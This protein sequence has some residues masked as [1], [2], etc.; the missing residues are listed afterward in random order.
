MANSITRDDDTIRIEPADK[1]RGVG[2]VGGREIRIDHLRPLRDVN[3]QWIAQTPFGWQRDLHK[4]PLRLST[5]G[6]ILWGE[7]DQGLRITTGFARELGIKVMLKPH[8]WTHAGWCGEI[9][10]TSEEDWAAWFDDYRNFILHYARFAEEH[11][12]DA[13]V[14]GTE[15]EGTTQRTEDWR[16]IIAAVR[17]VYTGPI[18]FGANWS[19]EFEHIEFWDELD[20]IG[21]HAY[22]PLSNGKKPTID[23]LRAN[24]QP[25]LERIERVQQRFNKPVLFTEIG[26]RAAEDAAIQPWQ[27]PRRGDERPPDDQTQAR[28][29]EAFFAEVW[30]KPWFAGVFFWKWYPATSN[31]GTFRPRGFTPQGNQAMF[32]MARAFRKATTQPDHATSQPQVSIDG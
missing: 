9:A 2:W 8:I 7:S 15:L 24:W 23:E 27:W 3:V 21:V 11:S 19:G 5:S 4:P 20:Y 14:I 32:V 12:I 13:L 17:D 28:L 31:E 18:T 16:Q 1:H 22:F 29:Y 26:Y 25:W 6:R 10:M 30:G